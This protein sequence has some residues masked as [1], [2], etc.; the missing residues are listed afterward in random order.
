MLDPRQS[1]QDSCSCGFG[2]QVEM[3]AESETENTI[4]NYVVAH[5]AD[6]RTLHHNRVVVQSRK[7]SLTVAKDCID[8]TQHSTTT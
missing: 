5:H 8:N 2:G 7:T 3:K 6:L 1:K 4:E